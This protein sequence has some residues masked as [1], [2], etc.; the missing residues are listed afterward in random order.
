MNRAGV[1][2]RS[3]FRKNVEAAIFNRFRYLAARFFY[4]RPV[5]PLD[6]R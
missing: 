3:G 2:G 5:A 4:Q 6:L 1:G